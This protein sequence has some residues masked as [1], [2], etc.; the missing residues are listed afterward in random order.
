[1]IFV[2]FVILVLDRTFVK[3]RDILP[4]VITVVGIYFL[5]SNSGVIDLNKGDLI[6]MMSPVMFAIYIV[7]LSRYSPGIDPVCFTVIQMAC[8][9]ILGLS[10]S[11]II[12]G[13]PDPAAYSSRAWTALAILCVFGTALP[14]LLQNVAQPHSSALAAGIIFSLM[15][16]FSLV[17]SI[18]LLGESLMWRGYLGGFLMVGAVIISKLIQV[19]KDK[20]DMAENAAGPPLT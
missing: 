9:G 10:T 14:F 19:R 17:A 18:I 15:P 16:L 20:K 8:V 5:G 4:I 11:L 2:P 13:F 12:D 1:V 7:L 3:L 6:S